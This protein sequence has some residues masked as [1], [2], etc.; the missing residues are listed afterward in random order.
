MIIVNGHGSIKKGLFDKYVTSPLDRVESKKIINSMFKKVEELLILKFGS[1]NF[2]EGKEKPEYDKFLESASVN[3][4]TPPIY[5]DSPN[6]LTGTG[7]F[8]NVH[9]GINSSGYTKDIAKRH[10]VISFELKGKIRHKY[11]KNW[12]DETIIKKY[13]LAD[14][15][16]EAISKFENWLINEYGN[17]F[18]GRMLLNLTYREHHFR[19]G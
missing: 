2:I 1:V 10:F 17:F 18:T 8:I 19:L 11:Q 7:A 13:I 14:N 12:N 15:E 6:F 16:L 5:I 9:T 3:I 4:F